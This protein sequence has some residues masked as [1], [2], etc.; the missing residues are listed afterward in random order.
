MT[1]HALRF[2]LVPVLAFTGCA[3]DGDP[4]ETY[5]FGLTADEVLA[6]KRVAQRPMSDADWLA[7]HV[8]PFACERYG[9]LC[10]TVGPDAAA[11]VIELGYR[12]AIAGG[13]RDAVVAAQDA[14]IVEAEHA[15][16]ARALATFISDTETTPGTGASNRRLQARADADDM[17]P[18]L[19]K[20]ADG[21]CWTQKH[22]VG[23]NPYYVD[24]ICGSLTANYNDGELILTRPLSCKTD[25][26][27][28]NFDFIQRPGDTLTTTVVCTAEEPPWR[29]NVTADV[30]N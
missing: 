17:W 25:A 2:A 30:T 28:I 8:G 1:R 12:I 23:W 3:T 26:H 11:Q 7:E 18:S 20:R 16:D 4:A 15:W 6:A 13:D 21:R 24:R 10:K 19:E 5:L 27:E 9:D 14:A 22:I 29:A